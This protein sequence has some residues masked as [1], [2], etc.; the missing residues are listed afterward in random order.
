MHGDGTSDE[1][2]DL[3]NDKDLKSQSLDK[4][5]NV[6]GMSDSSSDDYQDMLPSDR[7]YGGTNGGTMKTNRKNMPV[8]DSIASKKSLPRKKVGITPM[9]MTDDY[10]KQVKLPNYMAEDYSFLAEKQNKLSKEFDK[11]SVFKKKSDR[12]NRKQMQESVMKSIDPQSRKSD[13]D[14]SSKEPTVN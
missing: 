6:A 8:M 14:S 2:V 3:T 10:K 5:K 4:P 1:E 7:N 9:K 13:S 12:G 11:S